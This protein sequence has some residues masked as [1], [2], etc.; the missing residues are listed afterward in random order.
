MSTHP[1]VEADFEVQ[2]SPADD[3]AGGSADRVPVSTE[4]HEH[5]QLTFHGNELLEVVFMPHTDLKVPILV[6]LIARVGLEPE[7]RV[8]YLLVDIR[9][10]DSVDAEV[11]GIFN[12][13]SKGIC[14]AL[15]GSGPADRVLARFF[16]RKID[17]LRQLSY[18]ENRRDALT[19]LLEH[20]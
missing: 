4:D 1:A 2:D 18:V 7:R 8:K 15:L 9:G 11:A 19:Y 20:G 6:A 17:P 3:P 16:M 14:V 10:L 5:A 12:S 13:V